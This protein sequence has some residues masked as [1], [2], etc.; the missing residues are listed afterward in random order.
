MDRMRLI[1]VDAN[2]FA[3]EI[4]ALSYQCPQ[5]TQMASRRFEQLFDRN[6]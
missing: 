4:Q 5:S 3:L 6:N 2:D 1:N